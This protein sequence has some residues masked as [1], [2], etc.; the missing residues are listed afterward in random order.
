MVASPLPD[1][2]HRHLLQFFVAP[3]M[4]YGTRL[5]WAGLLIL[6]GFG[7]QL[8]VPID[9]VVTLLIGSLP[10]LLTGNLFLLVRGYNLRPT[11]SLRKGD[12]EKTTR[13]RFAK[14]RQLEREV[15]HWDESFTDLTCGSGVVAFI[16]LAIVVGAVG[17]VL[18]NSLTARFW[19]PVFVADAIVLLLPHWITGTRRGW[20]P[21]ALRQTID[22]LETA[23]RTIDKFDSP[24]CQIQPLFEM[25]GKGER[26]VPIGARVFIRFPDGPSGLLGLQFQVALNN[27]QGTNFPY[28]YAVIVAEEGF[29]LL[30]QFQTPIKQQ[31]Q[32]GSVRHK[33]KGGL[34]VESNREEEVEVII[35]RQ[36]TTKTSGYHTKPP[37]IR[38]IA[39]AAW[40][41]METILAST[42]VKA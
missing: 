17:L 23:L 25:A 6:A 31:A 18:A 30:K 7:F 16:L 11:Q 36:R 10:L 4:D 38:H 12:W 15:K 5:G 28:L 34:T 24:S 13:D 14:M 22:A 41:G 1:R 37:A 26:Q 27:V 33:K 32:G 40:Q 35:I 21:V 2:E 19:T 20:R 8:L 9:S 39:L 42:N 3:K 29:G